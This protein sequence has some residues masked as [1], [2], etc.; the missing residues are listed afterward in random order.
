ME[1][2]LKIVYR[3]F[4]DTNDENNSKSIRMI[5]E[6]TLGIDKELDTLRDV[7]SDKLFDEAWD[8]IT[9]G[10]SDLQEAAFISGFACCAKLIT[11]GKIDLLPTDQII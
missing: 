2:L 10:V 5:N 11:N 6:A 1:E 4:L 3:D 8:N 7:L 9:D